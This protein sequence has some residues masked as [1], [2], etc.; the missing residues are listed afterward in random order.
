MR[1]VNNFHIIN[2]ICGGDDINFI[3]FEKKIMRIYNI[4]NGEDLSESLPET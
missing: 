1:S 4:M 2:G 3:H